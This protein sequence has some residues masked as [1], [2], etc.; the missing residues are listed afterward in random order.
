MLYHLAAGVLFGA[1]GIA[2]MMMPMHFAPGVFYDG[3]SIVLSLAGLFGGPMAAG[4]AALM[5][6]AYRWNL[7]GAGMWPGVG[8]VVEAAAIGVVLHYLCRRDR[9]WFSPLRL[10][11]AGVVV[12][13]IM[14]LLQLLLLPEGKGWD[15]I[16]KIGLAVLVFYPLSFLLI[17][18]VYLDA[19]RRRTAEKSLRESEEQFRSLVEGA[20]DA[21]FVQAKGKFAYLNAAALRLFGASKRSELLGQPLMERVHPSL[22]EEVRQR[23]ESV[24]IHERRGEC[25]GHLRPQKARRPVGSGPEDGGRGTTGGRRGSRLQQYAANHSRLF[26]HASGRDG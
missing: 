5:C 11:L 15:V 7:G 16:V 1:V 12:H 26:G 9:K 25:Q 3:R 6:G 20:P 17:A 4:L 24:I 23:I 21:I 18:Q 13:V 2:G 10:W 19:Q 8:T 22:P 14:L